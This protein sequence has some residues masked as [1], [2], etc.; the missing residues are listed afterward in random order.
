MKKTLSL[1][2][3]F[4]IG[5]VGVPGCFNCNCPDSS[6]IAKYAD[7]EGLSSFISRQGPSVSGSGNIKDNDKVSWSDIHSFSVLYTIRTYGHHSPSQKILRYWGSAAYACDC[8]QPGYLG[9]PERLKFMTIKTVF[10]FDANYPAGS[11]LDEWVSVGFYPASETLK[12]YLAKGP[13]SGISLGRHD[14]VITKKP[15]A[16][17]SF[18]LDVTVELDNGEVYTTRTPVIELI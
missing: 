8:V 3:L 16:K 6:A 11:T 2:I 4:I 17:G 18:A 5:G 1:I 7:I 13:I 12:N 14:L 10:D 15:S 9:S